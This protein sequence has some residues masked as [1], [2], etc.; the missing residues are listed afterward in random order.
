LKVPKHTVFGGGLVI[1]LLLIALI[2]FGVVA[3]YYFF[4]GKKLE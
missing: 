3:L 1:G 2:M 4:K